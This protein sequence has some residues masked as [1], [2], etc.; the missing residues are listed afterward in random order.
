MEQMGRVF[1]LA[2]LLLCVPISVWGQEHRMPS[3]TMYQAGVDGKVHTYADADFACRMVGDSITRNSLHPPITYADGRF[4]THPTWG[5][6]CYY[7]ETDRSTGQTEYNSFRQN[8]VMPVPVCPVGYSQSRENGESVCTRNMF[9]LTPAKPNLQCANVGN[10]IACGNGAKI[11]YTRDELTAQLGL[12]RAYNSAPALDGVSNLF[13]GWWHSDLTRELIVT[14]VVPSTFQAAIAVREDG[15]VVAF[16]KTGSDPWRPEDDLRRYRLN[17]FEVSGEAFW[18]LRKPDNAQE[19]YD[20]KGRLLRDVRDGR[21]V[22]TYVRDANGKINSVVDAAGRTSTLTY[23]PQGTLSRIDLPDGQAIEYA[24]NVDGV[25]SSVTKSGAVSSYSYTR[26]VNRRALTEVSHDGVV[27]ATFGYDSSGRA[28]ST[29]HAGGVD[30]YAVDYGVDGTNVNVATPQGGSIQFQFQLK[31][32]S[33]I[34]TQRID[35]GSG[36]TIAAGNVYDTKANATARRRGDQLTCLYY[37]ADWLRVIAR[38]DY[39]AATTPQCPATDALA[40][41]STRLRSETTV[42]DTALDLPTQRQ[43]YT[44]SGALLAKQSYSY[45]ARGQALTSTATDPAV[46]ANTRSS[47]TTYCEQSD[48]TAGTCPL[49]GLVTSVD[50]P[51]T[52]VADLTTYTY[53]ASDDANCA[54]AP[55]TC[56]HRKGDLWKITN[57]LGQVVETLTYDGAGR[58]LSVKDPNGVVTD[59]EYHP[60]GWMTAQKIRG[61]DNAVETDDLITRIEYLPTG[62]VK[63]VT[64]PD[65]NY[66]EYGYDAAHRLTS[67]TD[68]SGWTIQYTLDNA[69]NRTVEDYK[70]SDGVMYRTLSRVYNQLGQLQTYKD[71]LNHG[72]GYAYDAA[73]NLDTTTDALGRVADNDHDPLGRLIR[74][75][76]DTAGIGAQ[77]Q[78]QYDALD[79]LTQVTDPKGLNTQYRY[80]GLGDLT[81][82]TSPDTGITTYTYDSAGNRKTQTDARNITAAYSYDA[83]GRMTQQAYPTA[84]LG[85]AYTYDTVAV[86]CPAGENFAQGRLSQSAGTGGTIRYCY[87]RFGRMV[88]K[89]TLTTGPALTLLYAYTPSGALKSVTYPDG[90]LVDYVR[91][92]HGQI[93]QIGVTRPG[94]S[95]EI[96]VTAVGYYPYSQS[97]GWVY[98]NGRPMTRNLNRNYE[99]YKLLGAPQDGLS[100]YLQRDA[101]GNVTRLS[102]ADQATILARYQY[103]ALNRLTQ[104]QDGPTGIALETYAYDATGNRTSMQNNAGAQ[105]YSY[106]VDSHRLQSVGSL[107]RTY[108]AVGN[109]ASIGGTAQEFVYNDLNRMSQ[110]KVNG[111]VQ[112]NYA[113]NGRGEQVRRYAGTNVRHAMYLEDGRWLGEYDNA[114]VAQQQVIWLDDLP[115]GVLAGDGATQKLHYVEPDHLGSPRAVIDPVRNAAI[116]KWQLKGE[117]FGAS[118]PEQDPDQDGTAFVF[119]MRYPGQRYDAANG[120]NYNHFRDY[121]ARAGRYTQSDPVG[122]LGGI[123][124]YAYAESNPGVHSDPYG[125]FPGSM[126]PWVR[127]QNSFNANMPRYPRQE[128]GTRCALKLPHRKCLAEVFE[129]AESDIALV[130]LRGESSYARS[131]PMFWWGRG[132]TTLSNRIFYT[133]PCSDFG[134]TQFILHEYYHVLRQWA[135]GMTVSGYL[136][137]SG[138]VESE[139][140]DF[141]RRNEDRFKSCLQSCPL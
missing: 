64:L 122:L 38:Y 33:H 129:V 37:D 6:G 118:P 87:D 124:S 72:R 91:S 78:F 22:A 63:K 15:R 65:G 36:A 112:M 60:R 56:P 59:M 116:W 40:A 130:E 132:A 55:T 81:Q 139:A 31:L 58:P 61:A 44:A 21:V 100:L 113:Y 68:R 25:L 134:G 20:A 62:L 74:T 131:F 19:I 42:W 4:G 80:N 108:D 111:V 114:G 47:A 79:R 32:G 50:G 71:G 98:G 135:K 77:T 48:I 99:V 70:K 73:G 110:V 97:A 66:T 95:R 46:P 102:T 101:V 57:A 49:L 29:E 5:T 89:T 69:G 16:T 90:A 141:A 23:T 54:T 93:T 7:D 41:A 67:V 53:Y 43:T 10:P 86:G 9:T 133:G 82:L 51:R 84:V 39:P 120:L 94:G 52:D 30:R 34:P 107:A 35:S 12:A 11:E 13:G 75:L 28:T 128:S 115:V 140:D 2:M 109:T 138:R 76:Q 8:Y 105:A 119:D 18:E 14:D 45:N 27:Y 106:P 96:V 26:I 126:N 117:A 136:T 125:L 1:V 85:T 3:M 88:R 127:L 123:S 104:T 121:E 103:D 24:Y 92:T 137:S 17:R 83:L